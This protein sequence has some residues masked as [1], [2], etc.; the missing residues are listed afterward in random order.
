MQDAAAYLVIMAVPLV[1]V[2]ALIRR[3]ARAGDAPASGDGGWLS[4]DSDGDGDGG[5]GG[6]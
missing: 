4:R 2:I 6:D 3:A 1:A 5:G